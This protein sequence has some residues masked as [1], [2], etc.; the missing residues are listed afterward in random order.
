MSFTIFP[1]IDLKS[2]QVVRL[3]E[4]DMARATIYSDDPAAQA[5]VFARGGAAWLHVVDLDGAFAGRS[6]NGEVV[7][8]IVAAFPG[9]VQ[10][11]GGIRDMAAVESW[12]A[13]GVTRAVIGTAALKDPEFV[14]A[15]AK[16]HPGRI[17]VAVDAK[18]G[19]VA[20]EGWAEASDMPVADLARRFEDAG[21]AAV[22]FTDVGRD[23]LLKGVNLEATH[24]LAK[25]QTLPVIASGGVAGEAD[26]V[27][28]KAIAADGI[29]GVIC[30]RAIY[31][32]RLDLGRALAI[33]A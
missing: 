19:M 32:G 8:R 27:A 22:L 4:G 29:T 23:G 25:A 20:T 9:K 15:A 6:V 3:A 12:F 7:A 11:G 31:D 28:L 30:G 5:A 10:L 13:R 21:V 16:M 2:G 14:K 17:V 24:A 26:I 33:A 1:A 18:G